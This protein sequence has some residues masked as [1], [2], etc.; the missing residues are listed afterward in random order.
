MGSN[1]T[2]RTMALLGRTWCGWVTFGSAWQGLPLGVR[3]LRRQSDELY[4]RVRF[5]ARGLRRGR[6][7]L[8]AAGRGEA[9][10]GE[11]WIRLFVNSVESD[12]KL[13]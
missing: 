3:W 13:C 11:W 10:L 2:A 1:P 5:P 4:D 12:T 7:R 9:R 6:S 8:G